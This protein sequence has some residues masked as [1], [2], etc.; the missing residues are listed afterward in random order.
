MVV[1]MAIPLSRAISIQRLPLKAAETG[2]RYSSSDQM[3][4]GEEPSVN[5]ER[6]KRCR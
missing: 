2:S 3:R 4:Y 6:Q 5:V 1:T